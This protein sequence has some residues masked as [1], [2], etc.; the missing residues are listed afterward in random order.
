MDRMKTVSVIGSNDATPDEA[1]LAFGLGE[2][3]G[4]LSCH[5]VCGGRGGVMERVAAGF[6]EA[7]A[8]GGRGGVVIGILPEADAGSANAHLDVAIPTGLGFHRN[9][10]VPL[11]GEAV[12]AVGG[13]AGTLSEISFAWMY[14]R[15]IALLGESGWA[16]RLAGAALDHRRPEPLRRFTDVEGAVVWLRRTLGI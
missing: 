6:R 11:A 12:I 5:L 4:A 1:A 9:G 2:A 14:G 13:G 8:A 3:L 16:D 15:P 7:R 10:I